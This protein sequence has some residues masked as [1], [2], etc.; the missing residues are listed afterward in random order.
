MNKT[1]K[2]KVTKEI[3]QGDIAALQ[4]II[5]D[6]NQKLDE[7]RKNERLFKQDSERH[8]KNWNDC[9]ARLTAI[10]TVITTALEVKHGVGIEPKQEWFRGQVVND[11]SDQDEAVRLLRHIHKLSNTNPPF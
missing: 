4:K 1:V 10:R 5:A 2:P 8:E 7:A 9:E 11:E 3:L 6:T